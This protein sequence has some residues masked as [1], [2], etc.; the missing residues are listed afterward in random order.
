[1]SLFGTR[2]RVLPH[3]RS[4][5]SLLYAAETVSELCYALCVFTRLPTAQGGLHPGG[6][7]PGRGSSSFLTCLHNACNALDR[8]AMQDL[9]NEVSA[10]GTGIHFFPPGDADYQLGRALRNA[11]LP[12][13]DAV[14]DGPRRR[15]IESIYEAFPT[16]P[17]PSLP[18]QAAS[19]PA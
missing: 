4:L 12:I 7:L 3:L 2:K 9:R 5:E 18:Q 15:F 10:S 11:D 6:D 8:N 14:P 17:Q 13:P 16:V 1:M 19:A